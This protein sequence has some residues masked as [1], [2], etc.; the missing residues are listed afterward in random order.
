MANDD[1]SNDTAPGRWAIVVLY[2]PPKLL[3]EGEEVPQ[4]GWSV[5][6]ETWVFKDGKPAGLFRG[7]TGGLEAGRWNLSYEWVGDRGPSTKEGVR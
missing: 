2:Q 6:E 3:L 4:C 5:L 7:L 1:R